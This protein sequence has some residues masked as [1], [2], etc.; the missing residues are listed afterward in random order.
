MSKLKEGLIK[1]YIDKNYNTDDSYLPKMIINDTSKN[2]KVLSYIEAELIKCDKFYFSVAFITESGVICLLNTLSY[3]EKKGIKGIIITSQ[4]QN[5]TTPKALKMLLKFS[6]IELKILKEEN[7]MHAKGYIFQRNDE[8]SMIIGSSNL[9]QNALG[10]NMEWNIKINSNEN[11]AIIQEVLD[12]FNKMYELSIEVTD[13]FIDEYKVIYNEYKSLNKKIELEYDNKLSDLYNNL[14]QPNSMQKEALERIK[15]SR[16]EGKN[17]ALVISATG[18]GKTYLAAFDV[19]EYNPKRF[20]FIV[21]RETIASAAMN[22]FKKVLGNNITMSVLSGNNKE[23]ES[24]FLF[25]TIQTIS[26]EEIY[27]QFKEDEFDYIVI[28]EVHRAGACMYNKIFDYFNPKF[29]LGM[30]ATPERNDRFDIYKLFDYNVPFEIRL[31]NAI[32][33]DLICPFHYFGVSE[34]SIDGELLDKNTDFRYLTSDERVKNIIE[35]VNLYGYSGNR[36]KGLIFCSLNNEAKELSIKLNDLGYKTM[37]LS[38]NDLQD[39]REIAIKLLEAEERKI[40]YILTVDIFNEGVDIPSINQILMLRPT[41]SAIIFIQQLG[42]GLR[43]NIEKEYVTVIDFIGNY[44]ENYL[45]PIAL[46]GDNSYNKDNIRK[47]ISEGS[48]IIPGASTVSFDEITKERIYKTIDVARFNVTKII[49]DSYEQLKKRLGRIPL[50]EDFDNYGAIQTFRIFDKYGSYHKFLKM[51]DKEYNI[52]FN[53]LEELYLEF[54]SCKLANGK[55]PHELLLL[56]LIINNEGD[57]LPLFKETMNNEYN[58]DLS[59]NS[60]ICSINIL[61]GKFIVGVEKE[62]YRKLNF[63]KGDIESIIISN[64]FNEILKNNLFKEKINELVNYGLMRNNKYYKNRYE[65]TNFNLYEKYTYDDICRLLEWHKAQ[66]AQNIGGYIYNQETNTFP[67]FINYN[68]DE[69]IND[70]IKYEDRFLS[71]SKLIA[72]SKARRTLNSKEIQRIYNYGDEQINIMLFVRKNKD[73]N[74]SKEFYFLGK[75]KPIGDPKEVIREKTND[76]VVEITYGLTNRIDGNLYDYLI[77]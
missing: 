1:G 43:K 35:K 74:E 19:K 39:D 9:T 50:H 5:F 8:Y 57:I 2:V 3:L 17:K 54:I 62:K 18:T 48:K 45:I 38:G 41:Q 20:L 76:K 30:S 22:S 56:K 29:L 31:S 28:D 67:V 60:L 14:I 25:A 55:K 42:R 40:D 52:V 34:I 44:E 58:I 27:H 77:G 13:S 32:D 16:V 73:D 46:S 59:L 15:L 65:D 75:M 66:V 33:A 7:N 23:F 64:E 51:Y 12:E 26:K 36:V 4:Y 63:I 69:T 68:K 11:G 70:S 72:Y 21:H 71:S 10:K 47:Y 49:K 53:E 6:N 37:A 61:S 24:D